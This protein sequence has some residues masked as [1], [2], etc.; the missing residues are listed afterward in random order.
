VIRNNIRLGAGLAWLLLAA[1]LLLAGRAQGQA[2]DPSSDETAA[3][4][5]EAEA[6]A[7]E[8]AA[9]Q[10]EVEARLEAAQARLEE[11][12]REVADL[13]ARL[14]EDGLY[15]AIRGLEAI[16]PRPMLGV[17]IGTSPETTE[18]GVHILG[19]TPDGPA[20]R[21]GLRS[22]DIMSG[23]DDEALVGSDGGERL[24]AVMKGVE[25]GQPVSVRY[26]RA[27]KEHT[28]TVVPE[29]MDPI[30]LV[31]GAPGGHWKLDLDGLESLAELEQLEELEALEGG[32]GFH[33]R[34]GFPGRWHALELVSLTPDLGQYFGVESGL[35]VVRS[36][37]DEA[38]G[39]KDGDVILAIDGRA[40]TS[41]QHAMRIL[42]SY[43]AGETIKFSIFRARENRTVEVQL[44]EKEALG[45]LWEWF[46]PPR[47]APAR[48][49][50]P[51]PR[52][53]V[54]T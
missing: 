5:E 14:T 9:R 43:E 26:R 20:D 27:G 1:S 6:R 45:R 49:P 35:L 13:S 22:G 3:R 52:P 7:E 15:L 12:A 17:N 16:G 21:A 23:I 31:I 30:R 18:P 34:T 19:V 53:P 11:A 54:G 10:A 38:L 46:T 40:P 33:F 48:V 29:E 47:P 41:P 32:P 28:A 50:A 37:K 51:P 4:Q 42:R 39:L 25:A 44:P 2:P 36:P 8:R 24:T